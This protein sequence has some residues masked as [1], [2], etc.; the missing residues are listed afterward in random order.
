MR[1]YL[2]RHGQALSKEV[3]PDRGLS[4]A[5]RQDVEKVAVFLK[6]KGIEVDA[7]WESGRKRASQTAEI[8]ATAVASR[9][10]VLRQDGMAP[11]DPV[12]PIIEKFASRQGQ[13]DYMLVGHMPFLGIL[14]SRL[15]LGTDA[16]E[17]A[18][19]RPAA[20]VC[21]EKGAGDQWAVGW[22][23]TPSLL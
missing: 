17:V 2:V 20:I 11:N 6:G 1:L 10:G 9:G 7:I 3:D 12:T 13:R 23:V 18:V 19:F 15:V 4:A 5:G 14:A 22:M 8:L 21:L 16:R